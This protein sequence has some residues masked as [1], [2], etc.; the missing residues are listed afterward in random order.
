MALRRP[1]LCPL[2]PA[3]LP[4]APLHL[5]TSAPRCTRPLARLLR[6]PSPSLQRR[7]HCE[8]GEHTKLISTQMYSIRCTLYHVNTHAMCAYLNL[9][10]AT[11]IQHCLRVC[12]QFETVACPLRAHKHTLLL[13]RCGPSRL[14]GD[15]NFF[16]AD[17]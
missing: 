6:A 15:Q 5:H 10:V 11:W 1:P 12:G 14:T 17:F 16:L 4:H 13:S 3:L 7:T 8:T 2:R 9:H